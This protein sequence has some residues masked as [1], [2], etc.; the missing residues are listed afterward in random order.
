MIWYIPAVSAEALSAGLYALSRPAGVRD[1]RDSVYLFGWRIDTKRNKW[2]EVDDAV[3]VRVHE[4]AELN[5]IA[6]ILQPF[7]DAEQLPANTNEA[8]AAYVESKR[9]EQ[10][11]IYNAFPA[12]FKAQA[13]ELRQMIE[14]GLLN[15]PNMIP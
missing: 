10:M 14:E 12:V 8:L 1:A 5:G 3:A 2:I 7:I 6:D 13:K 11:V 15:E 4:L 9:G